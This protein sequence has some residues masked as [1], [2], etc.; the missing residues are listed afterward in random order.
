MTKE[1]QHHAKKFQRVESEFCLQNIPPMF[2]IKFYKLALNG[3]ANGH[4]NGHKLNGSK[5]H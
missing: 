1:L 4:V 3:H 5:R 2:V